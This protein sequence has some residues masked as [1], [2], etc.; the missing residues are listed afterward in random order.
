MWKKKKSAE[1][2]PVPG[3][4]GL[5]KKKVLL[6]GVPAKPKDKYTA[7]LETGKLISSLLSE[8][9]DRQYAER[10]SLLKSLLKMWS[11]GKEVVLLEKPEGV[12]N[13]AYRVQPCVAVIVGT[14]V[15]TFTAGEIPGPERMELHNTLNRSISNIE[16][17]TLDSDDESSFVDTIH[18]KTENNDF[19]SIE[20]VNSCSNVADDGAQRLTELL[21]VMGGIGTGKD[22]DMPSHENTSLVLEDVS[23]I[24]G[25]GANCDNDLV[26]QDDLPSHDNS[27]S[28][29]LNNEGN[30][31]DIQDDASLFE[32]DNDCDLSLLADSLEQQDKSE[33]LKPSGPSG[34][35][36]LSESN[37]LC[38]CFPKKPTIR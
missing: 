9:G 3:A 27:V 24:S 34:A 25:T 12:D 13:N 14:A 36:D 6:N 1:I 11:A 8:N 29:C 10:H 33:P 7:S 20:T 4:S 35:S 38:W 18:I 19:I 5:V 37:L 21:E 15:E 16:I 26:Q 30:T 32:D 23:I 28:P 17:I 22:I 31:Q 2:E